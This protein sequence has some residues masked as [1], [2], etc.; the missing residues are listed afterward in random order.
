M[1]RAG[2]MPAQTDWSAWLTRNWSLLWQQVQCMY[3]CMNYIFSFFKKKN[4]TGG[5]SSD[6]FVCMCMSAIFV[7]IFNITLANT[8][9][10]F[11]YCILCTPPGAVPKTKPLPV[12]LFESGLNGP[13]ANL[14]EL[15]VKEQLAC[16]KE[17]WDLSEVSPTSCMCMS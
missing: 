6:R 17:G 8:L 2:V 1:E 15:L 12:K 4:K 13:L 7:C 14:A 10:T 3:M 5:W 16:F 9:S 11:Y